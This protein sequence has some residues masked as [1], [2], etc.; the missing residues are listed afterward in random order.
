VRREKEPGRA[1]AAVVGRLALAGVVAF[2]VVFLVYAFATARTDRQLEQR[3]IHE[4]VA[5]RGA[6][7]L[8]E[9]IEGIA[10]GSLPIGH[11]L[12]GLASV[13][14]QNA[15]GGGV[16]YLNGAVSTAG[17][18]SYFF[19][20]FLLKSTL[21]F[22][23]VTVLVLAAVARNPAA[24][25]DARCWLVAPAVLFL[26]SIGASYNIGIRHLL[27]VY[28]FL[29]LAGAGVLARALAAGRRAP[30]IALAAL[31]LISL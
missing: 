15:I 8:S 23:A 24:R 14:R 12:G 26:A 2:A 17:F 5:L 16:N 27:P 13:V 19:V 20:A 10:R 9:T 4:M 25:A 7:G 1:A 6:P 11:Y 18:P 30:A 29:A 3:V 31:P 21:A 22:L 28:P